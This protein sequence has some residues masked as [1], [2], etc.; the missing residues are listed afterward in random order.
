MCSCVPRR[1]W[2]HSWRYSVP[3]RWQGDR[4]GSEHA[5]RRFGLGSASVKVFF[6]VL[7]WLLFILEHSCVYVCVH[8]CVLYTHLSRCLFVILNSSSHLR[9]LRSL[10]I[11]RAHSLS[12]THCNFYMQA[13]IHTHHNDTLQVASSR[14]ESSR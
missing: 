11:A 7:R 6:G 13:R 9:F 12:L 4:D 2:S 3:E 14:S 8:V 1:S 10:S 5:Q